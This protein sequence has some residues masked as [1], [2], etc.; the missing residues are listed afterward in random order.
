MRQFMKEYKILETTLQMYQTNFNDEVFLR[1]KFQQKINQAYTC[2]EELRVKYEDMK[3]ELGGN[4]EVIAGQFMNHK[5]MKD[6]LETEIIKNG[7]LQKEIVFLGEKIKEL[8]GDIVV[9]NQE[10][11]DIKLVNNS[12]QDKKVDQEDVLDQLL[13]TIKNLKKQKSEGESK[14]S[15]QN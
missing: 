10:I 3:T 14:I 7:D 1:L 12:E 6:K 9:K 8:E 13:M 5:E 2:Y 4:R 15:E 11:L